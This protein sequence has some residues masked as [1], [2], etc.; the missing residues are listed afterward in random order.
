MRKQEGDNNYTIAIVWLKKGV[1]IGVDVESSLFAFPQLLLLWSDLRLAS[2]P[3][4]IANYP[5]NKLHTID[6]I[7]RPTVNAMKK[8]SEICEKLFSYIIIIGVAQ[9]IPHCLLLK[10][11]LPA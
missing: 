11:L 8:A 7:H 6:P 9:E 2:G 5:V 4:E 3:A 10:T 1:A